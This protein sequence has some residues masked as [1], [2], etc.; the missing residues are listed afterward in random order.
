M[1]DFSEE[2]GNIVPAEIEKQLSQI[3]SAACFINT[4]DGDLIYNDRFLEFFNI[5]SLKDM[6]KKSKNLLASFFSVK[7][8][9]LLTT[10]CTHLIKNPVKKNFKK[11]KLIDKRKRQLLLSLH[12]YNE[13]MKD[14]II[15]TFWDITNVENLINE[16]LQTNLQT[17]TLF[18]NVMAC[19]PGSVYWKD[20]HGKYLGCNQSVAD[21]AGVSSPEEVIG[22]D[23]FELFSHLI[24]TEEI[25]IA[26]LNDRKVIESRHSICV[27]ESYTLP[28]GGTSIFLVYKAPLRNENGEVFGVIGTSL[29]I[30]ESKIMQNKV[31]EGDKSKKRLIEQISS[32]VRTPLNFISLVIQM[33]L[34]AEK[35]IAKKEQLDTALGQCIAIENILSQSLDYLVLENDMTIAKSA[36]DLRWLIEDIVNDYYLK[37]ASKNNQIILDY[38]WEVPNNLEIQGVKRITDA[39]EVL[40]RNAI[41]FTNEGTVVVRVLVSEHSQNEAHLLIQ[42]EDNGIGIPEIRQAD[43]F[44]FYESN[45]VANAGFALSRTKRSLEQLGSDLKFNSKSGVGSL[46]WFGIDVNVR[47]ALKPPPIDLSNERIFV[48]DTQDLRGKSI[49]DIFPNHIAEYWSA[50]DL[51][52][53]LDSIEDYTRCIIDESVPESEVHQLLNVLDQLPSNKRVPIYLLSSQEV[54]SAHPTLG[55]RDSVYLIRKPIYATYFLQQFSHIPSILLIDDNAINLQIEATLLHQL[56]WL[57]DCASCVKEAIQIMDKHLLQYR[58]ILTD[59]QMPDGTGM[60][61][62]K[63]VNKLCETTHHEKIPVVAVSAHVSEDDLELYSREGFAGVVP[64]PVDLAHLQHILTSYLSPETRRANY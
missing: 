43:L 27:E 5:K 41:R 53:H 60:D 16:L 7:E 31:L 49:A 42:V 37:A 46:F 61:L 36:K 55:Y 63:Y 23:D 21:F 12:T 11:V 3:E 33:Y 38:T 56:G 39:L 40:L 8:L 9:E 22:K 34:R 13:N 26:R 45:K 10:A 29:N 2:T 17:D 20:L 25:E 47:S 32:E 57:A 24:S 30:T 6:A 4:N 1:V 19:M 28:E 50:E 52:N 14:G 48:R 35:N 51:I 59:I 44:G 54:L 58:L 64:K 62:L 18:E 15:L